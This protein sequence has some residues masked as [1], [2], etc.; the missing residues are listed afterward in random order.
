MLWTPTNIETQKWGFRRRY[1]VSALAAGVAVVDVGGGVVLVLVF[2][3]LTL[4]RRC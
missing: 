3:C 2:C 1:V 4:F